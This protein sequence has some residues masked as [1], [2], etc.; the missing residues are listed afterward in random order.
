MVFMYLKVVGYLNIKVQTKVSVP[1]CPTAVQSQR[2]THKHFIK[3]IQVTNKLFGL[4]AQACYKL[5]L[6][7]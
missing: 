5:A 1:P 2:N 7:T 6:T 4:L 3:E